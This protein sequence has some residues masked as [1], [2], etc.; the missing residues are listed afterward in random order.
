MSVAGPSHLPPP[1]ECMQP[2]DRSAADSARNRVTKKRSL[3]SFSLP[4]FSSRKSLQK[5]EGHDEE[6]D[7][8]RLIYEEPESFVESGLMSPRAITQEPPELSDAP[9]VE[10]DVAHLH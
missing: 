4:T 5:K 1:P 8:Q 3:L 10:L 7:A 6:A 2:D 9:Q